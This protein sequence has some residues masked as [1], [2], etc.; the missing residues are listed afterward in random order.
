MRLKE[1]FDVDESRFNPVPRNVIKRVYLLLFRQRYSMT[2][3]LRL[4]EYF[5][6]RYSE[7][8]NPLYRLLA[9]I[10]KRKNEVRNNFEHGYMHNIEPGVLF[11]HTG[12]TIND[13]ISIGKNVQIFKG[14]TFGLV[15]GQ[16]CNIGDNSIIFS[17]VIILGKKIGANCVVG[18]GSVVTKD[19][20]DNSIVAGNPARVIG[21]CINPLDYVEF[22]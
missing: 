20:P 1:C 17:H 11:H 22:K 5:Y 2:V 21:K 7:N 15:N 16:V 13:D 4:T 3:Y 9:D 8:K 12:V 19:I 6:G 14:V 10:F 18:A